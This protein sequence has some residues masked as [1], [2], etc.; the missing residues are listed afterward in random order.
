M[1]GSGQG[2]SCPSRD[3]CLEKWAGGQVLRFYFS[4]PVVRRR[5]AIRATAGSM[6]THPKTR[7]ARLDPI[8][9]DLDVRDCEG[10]KGHDG[11]ESLTNNA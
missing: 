4:V 2:A 3:W 8:V 7:N 11:K 10:G 1:N 9:P 5:R 6:P